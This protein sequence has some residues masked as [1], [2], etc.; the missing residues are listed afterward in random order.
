MMKRPSLPP[1]TLPVSNCR[2]AATFGTVGDGVSDDSAAMQRAIDSGFEL[3]E[4]PEG[5]YKISKTLR[6]PSGRWLRFH[7]RATVILADGAGVS[8][9]IHLIAN[10]DPTTGNEAIRIEGGVWDGNNRT[11]PRGGSERGD[12]TGVSMNFINVRNLELR[13]LRLRDAET[14][15]V[16]MAH[17]DNFE[18]IDFEFTATNPRPNQDGIHVAGNSHN[19]TISNI[20]GVGPSATKD[21]LVALVADDALARPQNLGLCCGPLSNITVSNLIADDCHSFVRLASV[22][23]PI[24]NIRVTSVTGGCEACA[25]NM[26]ALRYCAIRLFEDGD[27]EFATGAGF[28]SNIHLSDFNVFRSKNHLKN[29]LILLETL[30]ENFSLLDFT[31]LRDRDVAPEIPTLRVAHILADHL[32]VSTGEAQRNSWLNKN[33]IPIADASQDQV[34]AS[35]RGSLKPGDCLTSQ[36]NRLESIAINCT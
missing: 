5:T 30:V 3:I 21:D 9:D 28:C 10:A 8:E 32:M 29:P 26:D 23:N 20:R 17:V 33:G 19:G 36:M 25:I 14:Y 16:R 27:P 18:C 7:D 34:S 6:V 11:N 13:H 4:V 15:F 22:R 35:W 2:S 24:H 1:L 12:Y 31:R